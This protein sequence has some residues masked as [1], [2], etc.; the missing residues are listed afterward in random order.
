MKKKSGDKKAEELLFRA[1]QKESFEGDLV[2][3][4]EEYN[5]PTN[6]FETMK[7]SGNWRFANRAKI[8]EFIV[9]ECK[10]TAEAVLKEREYDRDLVKMLRK[11]ELPVT[12]LYLLEAYVLYNKP[13]DVPYEKLYFACAIDNPKWAGGPLSEDEHWEYMGIPY[14]RLLIHA[15]TNRSDVKKYIDDNW[16][17]IKRYFKSDTNKKKRI[18]VSTHKD[19]DNLI[20]E[21]SKKTVKELKETQSPE[22]KDA[23][24]V[25]NDRISHIVFEKT[26]EKLGQDNIKRIIAKE[27]K[28]RKL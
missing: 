28:R 4:R 16:W 5:I 12:L 1:S 7:E 11:Y 27:R 24:M 3:I 6:G 10:E 13:F 21:L 14:V 17:D 25:N 2:S 19:R 23:S 9:N 20:Y 18:R 26:G 8:A 15:D 22:F